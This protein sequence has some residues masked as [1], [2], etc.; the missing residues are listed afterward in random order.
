M[1]NWLFKNRGWLGLP[2]FLVAVI[3]AKAHLT[4]FLC[5]VLL[6]LLGESVRWA[7]VAFS[8]PTTRSKKVEAPRLATQGPYALVRNPIYWGNFFIGLGMTVSSAAFWPWLAF[9]FVFVFWLEYIPIILAEENYLKQRFGKEYESYTKSVHRLLILPKK[10]SWSNGQWKN[11]LKSEKST[12]IVIL[13]YYSTVALRLYLE[14]M[15]AHR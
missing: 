1:G 11:A 7:S 6:V 4:L 8:G 12:L 9:V 13:V 15:F 14:V 3:F 2:F 5:G 10:T